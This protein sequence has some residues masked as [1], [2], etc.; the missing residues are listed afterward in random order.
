MT[1]QSISKGY[2]ANQAH[3]QYRE[4]NWSYLHMNRWVGQTLIATAGAEPVP[5]LS[6]LPSFIPPKNYSFHPITQAPSPSRN[7]LH[8]SMA[9]TTHAQEGNPPELPK[10]DPVMCW[11]H[12]MVW[13]RLEEFFVVSFKGSLYQV[14]CSTRENSLFLCKVPGQIQRDCPLDQ[15][16]GIWSL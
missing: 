13:G 3:S 14:H 5:L 4:M 1:L 2:C 12:C 11:W 10:Q 8:A 9:I 15:E 16:E 7:L 6:L